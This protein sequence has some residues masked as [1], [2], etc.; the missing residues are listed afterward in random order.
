MEVVVTSGA[1]RRAKLQ[2]NRYHQQIN[3]QLF[4]GRMLILS[5]NK[6]C[7]SNEGKDTYLYTTYRL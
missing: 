5:P 3:T 1:L 6:Q 4:T 7:R 2:S